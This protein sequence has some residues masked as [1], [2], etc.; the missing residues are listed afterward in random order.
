MIDGMNFPYSSEHKNMLTSNAISLQDFPSIFSVNPVP[1]IKNFSLSTAIIQYVTKGTELKLYLTS[2]LSDGFKKA[3]ADKN[4]TLNRL[5]DYMISNGMGTMAY[6]TFKSAGK[7]YND[8]RSEW[9]NKRYIFQVIL[10]V[11]PIIISLLLIMFIPFILKV[12]WTLQRIYLHICRFN[13]QDIKKWLDACNSSANDIKASI[14]AMQGIYQNEVFEI[15]QADYEKKDKDKMQKTLQEK[16]AKVRD[17]TEEPEQKKQDSTATPNPA[18]AAENTVKEEEEKEELIKTTQE[19]DVSERKQK[20]FSQMSREKTKTY[21]IYLAIFIAYIGIFKIVDG[22][23]I[24]FLNTSTEK[25]LSTLLVFYTREW[26]QDKARQYFRENM[27]YNKITS[28]LD[29]INLSIYKIIRC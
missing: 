24:M 9:N 15:N 27:V 18:N 14:T 3:S 4:D 5:M 16:K 23:L 12:Q 20:T 19:I 29:C 2:F 7:S 28:D 17:E 25:H 11:D 10:I 8:M 21:L 6:F 22:V 13:D 26:D 1:L